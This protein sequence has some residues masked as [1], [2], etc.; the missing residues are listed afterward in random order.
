MYVCIY[1]RLYKF[2]LYA[3]TIKW[4]KWCKNSNIQINIVKLSP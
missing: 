1:I 2:I 4:C 3:E